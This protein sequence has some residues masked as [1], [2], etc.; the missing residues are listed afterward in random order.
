MRKRISEQNIFPNFD[1]F[2]EYRKIEMLLSEKKIACTY[3]SPGLRRENY[4]TIEEFIQYI[5]FNNWELRGTFTTIEEM[6]E[7]LGIK[8]ESITHKNFNEEQIL[9]F[10]QYALNCV[11]RISQII[12]EAYVSPLS[13][14]TVVPMLWKN[15]EKLIEKLNCRIEQNKSEFYILYN[16]PIEPIVEKNCPDIAGSMRE[17]I[18]IDNR[19]DLKRKAEILCTLYKKLEELSDQFKGTVY[20]KLYDDA[21]F[22]FNKACIRHF[23]KKGSNAFA[24]MNELE[25]EKWYDK[26]FDLFLSCMVIANYLKIN[27]DIDDVKRTFKN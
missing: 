26:T 8:K 12:R 3:V 6:R 24:E 22:L 1:L 16:N 18:R 7:G 9:D 15:V 20:K 14:D 25:L 19:G 2:Q 27:N 13:D 21:H 23:I 11:Y 5:G 10:L 4:Y 17:Y